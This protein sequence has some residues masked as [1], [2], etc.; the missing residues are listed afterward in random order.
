MADTSNS[1]P[2]R[3][4]N[5]V[6]VG[7][8]DSG[9]STTSSRLIYDLGG[10]DERTKVKLE[11]I[12][13]E[14][15]KPGFGFAYFMDTGKEERARGIT[16][17]CQTQCF[18]TDNWDY[19]LTDAP[20]H[21][22]FIKNMITGAGQADV[23]I[24]MVPADGNFEAAISKGTAAQA[25]GQTRQHAHLINNL[26]I[27]QI[28]VCINKMDI[29]K[30]GAYSEERYNE[31]RDEMA[32]MIGDAG[33]YPE[34]VPFI[35]ISG[36]GGENLKNPTENMPWYSGWTGLRDFTA[37]R[38]RKGYEILGGTEVSGFTLYDA[39]NNYMQRPEREVDGPL[40]ISI[41]GS[42]LKEVGLITTGRIET[43]TLNVGDIVR[44]A[45]SGLEGKVNSIE[46]HHNMVE[47][48]VAGFNV[49]MLVKFPKGTKTK[50]VKCGDFLFR[51]ADFVDTPDLMP[52][53][54]TSFRAMIQIK[55]HPGEL[56]VG[57]S[58][59]MFVRTGRSACRIAEIHWVMGKRTGGQKEENPQFVKKGEMAEITFQPQ[60][61]LY[62]EPFDQCEVYG[63]AAGM[64][65]KQL[66]TI[67]KVVSI[68][69][70][71]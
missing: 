69:Y 34:T 51:P 15:G 52:R 67:G 30:G 38:K 7:H 37:K 47:A 8:V 71:D 23:A 57:F 17:N 63:R 54:I 70:E 26:G 64:E 12:A 18:E 60:K 68:K 62:L 4:I 44:L 48:G 66:V 14:N 49:G 25:G 55:N 2:M 46:M 35:P 32:S 41:S 33:F 45:S 31:I 20:G 65:S 19:T 59:Q 6:V 29:A 43:G 10:I 1:D 16:I 53:R 5:V 58:P 13:A 21:A 11:E 61:F 36:L 56:K 24:L 39:L 28:I 22:D 50:S 9:K 3:K 27:K 42:T 40:R